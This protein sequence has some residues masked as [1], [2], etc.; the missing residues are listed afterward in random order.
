MIRRPPRS[1][2]FPYTTLFRSGHEGHEL[3][4]IAERRRGDL[5][6][7]EVLSSLVFEPGNELLAGNAD[8][9]DGDAAHVGDAVVLARA[10]AVREARVHR[11]DR[12]LR[13]QGR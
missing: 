1:T 12:R 7:E 10:R 4:G 11:P 5:N 2:L 8:E 6:E 13:E 9:L 3:I